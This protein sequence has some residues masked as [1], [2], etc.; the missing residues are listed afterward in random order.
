MTIPANSA[1]VSTDSLREHLREIQ[2]EHPGWNVDPIPE[3]GWIVATYAYSIAE[4]QAMHVAVALGIS[5]GGRHAAPMVS[6][7]RMTAPGI[8]YAIADEIHAWS[9][10]MALAEVAA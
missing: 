10:A 1:P 3:N 7:Y 4:M 2:A 9:H 5:V 8:A 6:L